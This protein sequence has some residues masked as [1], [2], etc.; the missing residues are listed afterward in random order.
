MNAILLKAIEKANIIPIDGDAQ[1]VN[2][3]MEEL[4]GM[5]ASITRNLGEI[6]L[7]TMNVLKG[8]HTKAKS[9]NLSDADRNMVSDGSR[10]V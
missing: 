7:L 10:T 6:V 1:L 4:R 5:D 9:G 3:K 2:R 8:L